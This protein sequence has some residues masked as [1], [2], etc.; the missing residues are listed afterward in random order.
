M[1]LWARDFDL[2]FRNDPNKAQK[3]KWLAQR[4]TASKVEK[5]GFELFDLRCTMSRA[6]GQAVFESTGG[7]SP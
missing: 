2:H 3:G 4:Y 1:I 5:H 6:V 7:L